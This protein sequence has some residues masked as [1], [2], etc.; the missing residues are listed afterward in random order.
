MSNEIAK[1]Y[2]LKFE[3]IHKR[4]RANDVEVRK[5]RLRKKLSRRTFGGYF[6]CLTKELCALLLLP[7]H[8]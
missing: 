6:F 3:E 7:S 4:W 1:P 2:P 8:F 5:K